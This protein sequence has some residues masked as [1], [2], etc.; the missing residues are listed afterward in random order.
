MRSL[1]RGDGRDWFTMVLI[2][3]GMLLILSIILAP[4]VRIVMDRFHFWDFRKQCEV[5]S[6]ETGQVVCNYVKKERKAPRS[7]IN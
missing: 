6:A 7:E 1:F 3:C 4:A 5:V 2:L